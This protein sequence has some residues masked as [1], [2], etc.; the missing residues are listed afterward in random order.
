[1]RSIDR[2][3]FK[4]HTQIDFDSVVNDFCTGCPKKMRLK[5]FCFRNLTGQYS[6]NLQNLCVYPPYL[7]H[8]YGG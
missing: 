5:K 1:M 8:I 2:L 7:P 4:T 6:S 3:K